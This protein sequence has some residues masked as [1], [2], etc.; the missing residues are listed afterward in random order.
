MGEE[1]ARRG[2]RVVCGGY[3]GVMEAA[4]RGAADAG[5]ESLG[6]LIEGAGEP[7]RWVTRAVREAHLGA[8]LH[9]LLT[10]TRAAIFLPR[11]LGTLLEAVFFAESVVKGHTAP[12]PL[13][14]LGE[15]WLPTTQEAMAQA[16][17]AGAARLVDCFRF[18]ATPEEAARMALEPAGAPRA[19][20]SG[21][22]S[23][24]AAGPAGP[25]ED[26]SK[27]AIPNRPPLR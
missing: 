10:E 5:G 12:R 25:R 8:R 22:P 14:F 24:G 17:G 7:N 1:L 11:G 4:C 2:A 15:P 21:R 13:V 9:R 6:V 19:S 18:A 3:G 23:P 16:G 20:S 27:T 26:A